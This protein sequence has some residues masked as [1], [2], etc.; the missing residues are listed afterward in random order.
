MEKYNRAFGRHL[1]PVQ[2]KAETGEDAIRDDNH[3]TTRKVL[4]HIHVVLQ[5]M[6][7]YPARVVTSL[8]AVNNIPIDSD[9]FTSNL[10]L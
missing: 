1:L 7:T 10:P 3:Q 5:A 4:Q 9:T 6:C 2:E 8:P